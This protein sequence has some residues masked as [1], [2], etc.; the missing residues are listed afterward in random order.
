MPK[1]T[2]VSFLESLKKSIPILKRT[3]IPGDFEETLRLIFREGDSLID[4]ER[5]NIIVSSFHLPPAKRGF[6]SYYFG[7]AI[8][9]TEAFEAGLTK[10]L[11][12]LL[13]HF[14]DVHRGYVALND[15]DDIKAFIATHQ[16]D[17]AEFKAR[18]SWTVI[19]DIPPHERGYLGYV[20]GERPFRHRAF[21]DIAEKVLNALDSDKDR[22]KN[23]KAED[24]SA[25]VRKQLETEE[26]QKLSIST[27]EFKGLDLFEFAA[28]EGNKNR[29]RELSDQVNQTITKVNELKKIGLRNQIHFLRNIEMID[30]YVATSMRDDREYSEM[31]TFVSETF[32]KPEIKELK[33]RYFDPTL[34]YC[35]SRI[36][37]GIVECLL[38]RCAKATVYCAQE[39]D[40]FGKDSELAATLCQ[41]K[42]VIVYVPTAPKDLELNAKLDKRAK[43]FR[44]FHPL[45]LQVGLYDG[46]ARGVIVVRSPDQCARI[47]RQILTNNLEVKV[48]FEQHGIVLREVE[49]DSVLRVM[50]GWRELASCFWHNF[51]ISEDPKSGRPQ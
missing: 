14:G 25:D 51:G 5:F 32:S 46:V 18:S 37:K 13:W 2:P 16:F 12:D 10:L 47:L 30:V 3:A 42:P 38:V 49:T 43:T 27:T 34:C 31:Y 15:V 41:G 29:V 9:T 11:K 36:D 48:T 19:E 22:Y 33:L 6:F 45:G 4:R 40:T 17:V 7:E 23:M 20:S 1:L 8:T 39:G 26:V 28:L 24:I 35:E 21:L 44:E 50:T